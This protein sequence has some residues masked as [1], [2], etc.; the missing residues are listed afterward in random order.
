MKKFRLPFTSDRLMVRVKTILSKD[1][2]TCFS[3]F[4]PLPY[5]LC[6]HTNVFART[7]KPHEEF[8][9]HHCFNLCLTKTHEA[10]STT[11]D[12]F[13]VTEVYFIGV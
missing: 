11:A 1:K 5:S 4:Y 7:N 2:V 3:S 12:C 9:F 6:I 8:F 10:I 13:V